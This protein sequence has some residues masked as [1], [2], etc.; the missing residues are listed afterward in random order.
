MAKRLVKKS[1]ANNT[2]KKAVNKTKSNVK[3]EIT[4]NN[5]KEKEEENITVNNEIEDATVSN[6]MV[7]FTNLA[8]V[9]AVN[10]Y[11]SMFANDDGIII[12]P[13][14]ANGI[15]NITV[16]NPIKAEAL[17]K[18][19]KPYYKETDIKI[20]INEFKF[21]NNQELVASAFN[22]T[23]CV[24]GITNN[25]SDANKPYLIFNSDVVQ[26]EGNT[27]EPNGYWTGLYA[28]I[29]KTICN[30]DFAKFTTKTPLMKLDNDKTD[31]IV[32]DAIENNDNTISIEETDDDTLSIVEN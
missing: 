16:M 26:F 14:E 17:K 22:N 10:M 31:S 21:A 20:A 23:P 1:T 6:E 24:V 7:K 15:I 3:D 19:L 4:V 12:R 30:D 2:K 32:V 25:D 18:L 5:E 8:W 28:D 11:V 9:E 27:D 13:D 29:A